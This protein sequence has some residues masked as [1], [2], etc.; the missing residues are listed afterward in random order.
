M[1]DSSTRTPWNYKGG[2]LEL[3]PKENRK[4]DWWALGL[5]ILLLLPG[6]N[7][8]VNYLRFIFG[9]SFAKTLQNISATVP[10]PTKN[11]TKSGKEHYPTWVRE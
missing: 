1:N 4:Y 9:F 7:N 10:N 11:T 5:T 2:N 8:I 3:I 6:L